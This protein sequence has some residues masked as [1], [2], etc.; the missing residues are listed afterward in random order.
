MEADEVLMAHTQAGDREAFG[1]LAAR[2]EIPLFRFFCRMG[3]DADVAADLFQEAILQLYERR[4]AYDPARPLP[5]V[6]LWDRSPGVE[7]LAPPE[8]PKT[9]TPQQV[10]SH[11]AR[12]AGGATSGAG[13]GHGA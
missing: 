10:G 8:C 3:A 7:R 6:A 4:D 1:R 12:V 2:Y 9:R 11:G 5:P 13:P